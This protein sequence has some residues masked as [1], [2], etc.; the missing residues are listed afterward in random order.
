MVND[1]TGLELMRLLEANPQASQRDVACQ[2]GFSLGKVNYCIRALAHRGWIKARRFKNS[3]NKSAYMYLLTP[4]GIEQKAILAA[5]FLRIKMREYE[6]LRAEIE[7][8]RREVAE[9]GAPTSV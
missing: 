4:C 2:F 5:R 3:R 1:E 7:Q 8:L 9:H 6:A